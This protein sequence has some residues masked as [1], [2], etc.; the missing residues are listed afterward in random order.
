MLA[1]SLVLWQALRGQPILG[2]DALTLSAWAAWLAALVLGLVLILKTN[3][4]TPQM[5]RHS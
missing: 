3:N 4:A 5:E 2:S 1:F